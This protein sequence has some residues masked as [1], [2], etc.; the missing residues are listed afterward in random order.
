MIRILCVWMLAVT[1]YAAVERDPFSDDHFNITYHKPYIDIQA[2]GVSA[3][4]V[5]KAIAQAAEQNIVMVDRMDNSIDLQW[6]HVHWE[7]AIDLLCAQLGCHIERGTGVWVLSKTSS[8]EGKVLRVFPLHYMKASAIVDVLKQNTAGFG[9]Q[10]FISADPKSNTLVVHVDGASMDWITA[11]VKDLDKPAQQVLI[12]ARIINANETFAKELGVA[13]SAMQ[14]NSGI[15]A[16]E[17][18]TSGFGHFNLGVARLPLDTQLDVMISAAQKNHQTRVLAMPKI[19]TANE[20]EAHIKQGKE[21]AFEETSA[22]G[23]TSVKFKE[24]VLEL[25]VVPHISPNR[26]IILD[27]TVKH[28]VPGKLG[29]NGQPTIDTQSIR[30][31]VRMND[32]E[33]IVLGGIFSQTS[34]SREFKVPLLHK[35]PLLGHLFQEH[36]DRDD[37]EELLVFVTPHLV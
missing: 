34:L 17:G 3:N 20:Q 1:A 30:T 4:K 27:L 32:G 13:F 10:S 29:D 19:L 24:A 35:I 22:S 6:V 11:L 28:D 26:E 21:L 2:E 18:V 36:H 7:Q 12:Q 5:I 25:R 37:K 9:D 16:G 14:K 31:Q 33:T 15:T 23:A 8:Q